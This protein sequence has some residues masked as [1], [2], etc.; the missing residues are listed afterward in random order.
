MSYFETITHVTAFKARRT[1]V[2][3]SRDINKWKEIPPG[4]KWSTAELDAARLIVRKITEPSHMLPALRNHANKAKEVRSQKQIQELVKGP[5]RP[6]K[7]LT[8]TELVHLYGDGPGYLWV[9]LSRFRPH[10]GNNNV[11][12]VTRPNLGFHPEL[13]TFEI[14]ALFLWHVA[15][16]CPPQND[17]RHSKPECLVQF[18]SLPR[19][20]AAD[21]GAG[22]QIRTTAD[23]ELTLHVLDENENY[24]REKTHCPALVAAK[25]QFHDV[26]DGL[27]VL[28]DSL[29]GQLTC[30]ALALRLS[31]ARAGSHKGDKKYGKAALRRNCAP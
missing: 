13:A 4:D 30:E 11:A 20:L 7:I 3:N 25:K 9:L 8:R 22:A 17:T 14:A 10:H 1:A 16:S 2:A 28:T 12:P 15:W 19:Q 21:T 5:H 31:L 24:K 18:Q 29:L 26:K 23:A 6:W 27:P